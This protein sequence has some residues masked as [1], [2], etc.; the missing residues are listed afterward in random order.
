MPKLCWCRS[1]SANI[2]SEKDGEKLSLADF[3]SEDK[4]TFTFS[5]EHSRMDNEKDSSG[6]NLTYFHKT[7]YASALSTARLNPESTELL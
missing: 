6:N 2:I 4:G 3:G 1:F 7:D 5:L